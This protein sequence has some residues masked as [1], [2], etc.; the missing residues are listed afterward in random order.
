LDLTDSGIAETKK[1]RRQEREARGEF[2]KP[3]PNADPFRYKW[4]EED[5]G[6]DINLLGSGNKK[7]GCG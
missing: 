5:D 7:G 4:F 3:D 6:E 2:K 1:K